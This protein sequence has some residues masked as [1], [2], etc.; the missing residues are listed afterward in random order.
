MHLQAVSDDT[1]SLS[2]VMWQ[3]R[4]DVDISELLDNP[5]NQM[6]VQPWVKPTNVANIR[7]MTPF[8][9]LNG[10]YAPTPHQHAH[11]DK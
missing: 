11:S 3:P 1:F 6:A 8:I 10:I 5:F 7:G 2:P 9:F 4:T